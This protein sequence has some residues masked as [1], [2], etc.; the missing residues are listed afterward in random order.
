MGLWLTPSGFSFA[1]PV[2][3]VKDLQGVDILMSKFKIFNSFLNFDQSYFTTDLL[4][5]LVRLNPTIFFSHFL[6]ANS[7]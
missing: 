3:V 6:M 4:D 2:N 1:K 7:M 5:P